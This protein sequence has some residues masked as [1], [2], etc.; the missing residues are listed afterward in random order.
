METMF[1]LRQGSLLASEITP[2]FQ[3][4]GLQDVIKEK[5]G[6][7][8]IPLDADVA[9]AFERLAE[10]NTSRATDERTREIYSTTISS[11]RD[12]LDLTSGHPRTWHHFIWWP[13]TIGSEY[14]SLLARREPMALVIFVYWSAI[15]QNAPKRWFLDGWAAR[16][17]APIF[18]SLGPESND[19]LAWPRMALRLRNG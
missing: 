7:T 18:E 11:L 6:N 4:S 13:S 9:L 12:W 5:L 17:A 8:D 2:W 15:M 16:V 14:M 19:I 1:V 10:H 3:A